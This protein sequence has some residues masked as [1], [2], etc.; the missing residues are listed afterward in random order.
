MI[1][2]ALLNKIDKIAKARGWYPE[3][4]TDPRQMKMEA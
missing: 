1:G 4:T 2:N 3:E